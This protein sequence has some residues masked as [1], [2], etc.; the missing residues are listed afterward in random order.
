MQ[1]II[2]RLDAKN[3]GLK[4]YF[5]GKKCKHGHFA[6]RFTATGECHEC[7]KLKGINAARNRRLLNPELEREKDKI[8][9]RKDNRRKLSNEKW[10]AN[11]KEKQNNS[12]K[13][14]ILKNRKHVN[15]IHSKYRAKKK[16]ATPIWADLNKIKKIY[17][18]CNDNFQVDHIVPLNSKLVCGLHCEFNLQYLDAKENIIKGNRYWPDMP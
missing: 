10:R 18:E 7:S 11:N 5:T 3:L 8:R 1:K 13:N 14:W 9:Y 6:E 12:I 2:L 4:R 16:N 17:L 15:S